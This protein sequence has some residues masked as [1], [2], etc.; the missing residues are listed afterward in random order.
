MSLEWNLENI[1]LALGCEPV[2]TGEA[3]SASGVSIDSRTLRA[4]EIFV[5]VRGDRTDGHLYIPDARAAGAAALI[6]E[7]RFLTGGGEAVDSPV[8]GPAVF[9]VENG[10]G[11]LQ[12]LARFH[13]TR[14]T[15]PVLAITGSNGKTSAREMTAGLAARLLGEDRV[16]ATRGNLN[17]HFGAPLSLLGA[18][19]EHE[20]IVLELGMN[21][22]GEI[23]LLSEIVRPDQALVTSIAGAHMEFFDSLEDIARAKLE[24][25]K[26]MTS[27]ARLLW[28]S[29]AIGRE[30]VLRES[31]RR[32]IQ[33]VFFGFH[34]GP[35]TTEVGHD[36]QV[37]AAGVHFEWRGHR[38]QNQQ[39]F[40]EAMASNLLGSLA[41]LTNAGFEA[42]DLAVAASGLRPSTGRRFEAVRLGTGQLLIDDTYNANEASFVSSIQG[43]R[44]ILPGAQLG[45]FAGPMAELGSWSEEAHRAVARAAAAADYVFLGVCGGVLA[46]VLKEEFER[47]APGARVLQANDATELARLALDQGYLEGLQGILVKG[48]RSARMD[49]VSDAIRA[50]DA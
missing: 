43:L 24:I 40:T 30:E 28:N 5:C 15:A 35:G 27:G 18:N 36:L 11:A 4:G 21:H 10:L 46:E 33:P 3:R 7:E 8:G 13:R 16:H 44:K 26:G 48:S 37:S 6:V 25:V 29:D 42:G 20:L 45:L 49:L 2:R 50:R 38:V 9:A 47:A 34:V 1:A 17:N 39:Y 31:S 19:L 12:D 23:A 32:G 41:L 14:I 22:A